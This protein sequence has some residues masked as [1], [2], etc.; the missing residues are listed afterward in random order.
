M[1][2]V[3]HNAMGPVRPADH[4]AKAVSFLVMQEKDREKIFLD[5]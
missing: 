4:E 3:N 1:S 5:F 2:D